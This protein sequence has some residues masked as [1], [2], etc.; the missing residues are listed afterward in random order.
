VKTW[1][2]TGHCCAAG[3]RPSRGARDRAQ[4]RDLIVELLTAWDTPPDGSV[5]ICVPTRQ[6]VTEVV[7]RLATDGIAA[8]EIGPDGPKAGEGVH[9]GTVHPLK[10]L[11][12]QKI[13][14]AGV[15]DGLVP[16][17]TTNRY[18]DTIR[19]ATNANDRSSSSPPPA[20]ATNSPSSGTDH[21][22]RSCPAAWY[23]QRQDE[24][25]PSR[26]VHVRSNGGWSGR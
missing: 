6:L 25:R 10:G 8:V 21:R 20:P 1:P 5:A 16:R 12:Y 11:E 4:E 26:R 14:I 9:V 24:R 17:R 23:N 3:G 22:A 13:I 15:S 7:A 2:A 19:S 18:R